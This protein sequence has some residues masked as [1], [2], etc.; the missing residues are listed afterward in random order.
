MDKKSTLATSGEITPPRRA[1][2]G[3]ATAVDRVRP[4]PAV[5]RAV[6]ILRVL[7]RSAE[8][9]GVKA[10]AD[11]LAIVPSTCLH[12][13][14]VLV[15]EQLVRLDPVTRR[16]SLGNGLASLARAALARDPF[17]ALAQPALDRLSQR[18]KVTAIGVQ[19]VALEHM[20][21]LAISRSEAPFRLHVDVGSRFPAL[22]S[23]TGRLVAAFTPWSPGELETRFRK[24]RWQKAP[25]Y[26]RWL[27]EVAE[28][29]ERGYSLDE[30]D[31]IAGVTLV[32]V[33]VFDSAGGLS[34]ALV[35]AEMGE[36][37]SARARRGLID[38]LLE[39]ARTLSTALA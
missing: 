3:P 20:L 19:I 1:R 26:R 13:L 38:D 4:V 5:S 37:N 8:P 12:I 34:H 39:Q 36:S 18:W 28:V 25:G 10:I 2:P 32:A 30:G 24:L 21:V 33:P 22:I 6:A 16:Y 29:R 35:A 11:Q 7:G 27:K 14:R 9:L 15:S 31:Y 23:A 17:P